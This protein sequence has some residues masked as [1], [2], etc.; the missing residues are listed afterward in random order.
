MEIKNKI[1]NLEEE[2]RFNNSLTPTIPINVIE[3][4]MNES[5]YSERQK[6]LPLKANKKYFVRFAA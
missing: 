1:E 4:R 5:W 2:S 3:P 6:I